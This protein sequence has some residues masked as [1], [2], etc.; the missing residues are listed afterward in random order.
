MHVFRE[1][2]PCRLAGSIL[3]PMKHGKTVGLALGGGGARGLV[4]IL[5]LELLEEFGIRP[6]AISGTSIGAVFGALYCSG[7]GAGELREYVDRHVLISGDKT[8]WKEDGRKM[9]EM[10]KLLDINF[11]G[12]GLIKGDRF[13]HFLYEMLGGESFADLE[14]P[15]TVAATDF[16]ESSQVVL[17]EGPVLPAVKASMSVPGVFAPVVH[18]GR[19]LVDG[20]CVNPVPWDLLPECD[21]VIGVNALGRSNAPESPRPPKAAKAVLETFEIMQRG[22]LAEKLRFSPPDY[23]VDPP[24]RDVGILDFHKAMSVYEQSEAAVAGLRSFLEERFGRPG[25]RSAG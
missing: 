8:N 5:V 21:V 2:L 3:D 23:L 16:W 24:I 20:A 7:H 6:K 15:L 12:T 11:A 25:A 9:M 14:T 1:A 4:H 19:V 13:S 18:L 17:G 22:I 10:V